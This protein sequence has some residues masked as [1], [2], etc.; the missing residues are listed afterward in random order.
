M[1]GNACLGE[2]AFEPAAAAISLGAQRV[3]VLAEG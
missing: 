1:F 3:S 2:L